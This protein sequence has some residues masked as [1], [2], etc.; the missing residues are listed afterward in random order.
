MTCMIFL[1]FKYNAKNGSW[2]FND[3]TEIP[4][5]MAN[6]WAHKQ[7]PGECVK[8]SVIRTNRTDMNKIGI[9]QLDFTTTVCNSDPNEYLCQASP[10]GNLY[11]TLKELIVCIF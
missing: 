8:A 5:V 10:M 7:S 3:E 1:G 4:R 2:L 6:W 9:S 11:L